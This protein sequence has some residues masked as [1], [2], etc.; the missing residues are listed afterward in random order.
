MALSSAPKDGRYAQ[1]PTH[2]LAALTL[3]SYRCEEAIAAFQTRHF[4]DVELASK[5]WSFGLS[6]EM[7]LLNSL[8][9]TIAIAH[10]Q[11]QDLYY[12]LL[13]ECQ[14]AA[15]FLG[16]PLIQPPEIFHQ[17]QRAV[18]SASREI[19]DAIDPRLIARVHIS[20][21][22][23]A[24]DLRNIGLCEDI[25]RKALPVIEHVHNTYLGINRWW[26]WREDASSGEAESWWINV[27]E[28]R[29]WVC[30][31]YLWLHFDRD[32]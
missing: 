20:P 22:N 29:P 25:L 3:L 15:I 32:T 13:G 2:L 24:S 12:T 9:L 23:L 7:V 18:S 5:R 8:N 30:L 11:I 6:L 14:V 19:I 28:P 4:A 27:D 1:C 26:E 21:K 16:Q 10:K 17:I 31:N